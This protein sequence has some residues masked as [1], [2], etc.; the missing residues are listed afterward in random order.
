MSTIA[1]MEDALLL[2]EYVARNS[3]DAFRELVN[4]HL[5][6]VYATAL[7][8]VCCTHLA[9]DVCQAV[10]IALAQKAHSFSQDV[11]LEGWLFRATR[12]VATNAL[13]TE[14]RYQHK[15]QEA[16][17][18][19][20]Q[21]DTD[22]DQNTWEQIVPILNE[23]MGKLGEKDRNAVLLRFFKQQ[24]FRQVAQRLGTTEDA[25]KKRVARALKSLAHLMAQRGVAVPAT[26][27][28]AT[29]SANAANSAPVGLALSVVS[30]AAS[31]GV[32]AS[33]SILTLKK[34]T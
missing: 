6:L 31:R 20:I 9:E 16:S 18:M 30:I 27:L 26:V 19:Q 13:R 12:F 14:R 32:V 22:I 7:R 10:F 21:T 15:I 3:E 25:A 28:A 23:T 5:D 17:R 8:Q 11:I 24:P 33:G 2:R 34:G 29:I 1:V 4:R